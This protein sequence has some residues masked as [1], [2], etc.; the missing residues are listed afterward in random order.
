MF[1]Y[2][3]NIDKDTLS[4]VKLLK[5]QKLWKNQLLGKLQIARVYS[6]EALIKH[7]LRGEKFIEK[8]GKDLGV[9]FYPEK[10]IWYIEDEGQR[11]LNCRAR[12]DLAIG[13]VSNGDEYIIPIEIKKVVS[14]SIYFKLIT[15]LSCAFWFNSKFWHDAL[16]DDKSEFTRMLVLSYWSRIDM[17]KYELL[18]ESIELLRDPI[19]SKNTII[20]A[21]QEIK[22]GLDKPKTFLK[23]IK[24][25]YKKLEIPKKLI[26]IS[27][28]LY[29]VRKMPEIQT[30]QLQKVFPE[31]LKATIEEL[32]SIPEDELYEAIDELP[33][34]VVSHLPPRIVPYLK[35]KHIRYLSPE[36]LHFLTPEQLK[37]LTPEQIQYLTPEQLKHL[38]PEQLIQISGDTLLNL[39][40]NKKFLKKLTKEQINKIMEILKKQLENY[41]N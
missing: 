27:V 4:L 24:K 11:V 10:I 30:P 29:I 32:E 22:N 34:I 20:N 28:I 15:Q 5:K 36:Q 8:M 38:K 14:R 1:E 33:P 12:P 18:T 19:K 2:Y 25:V 6:F 13:Y 40:S 21:L 23:R 16:E 3:E 7:V 9:P 41:G 26:V 31:V 35:P 17:K 39:L 37:Y